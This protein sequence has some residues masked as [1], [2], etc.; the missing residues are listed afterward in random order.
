M[1][2]TYS[3][4]PPSPERHR[5]YKTIEELHIEKYC[6]NEILS[7]PIVQIAGLP[8]LILAHAREM[9]HRVC[10]MC[11]STQDYIILILHQVRKDRV[12]LVATV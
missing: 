1:T 3:L 2:L 11:A 12:L 10:I 6:R 4:T 8:D 7:F 9:H 5:A